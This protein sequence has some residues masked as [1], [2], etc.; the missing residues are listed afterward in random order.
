MLQTVSRAVR[1][2]LALAEQP[3]GLT[4]SELARTVGS[5]KATVHRIVSTLKGFDLIATSG[6]SSRLRIG[7]QCAVLHKWLPEETDIREVARPY[8]TR[9]RDATGET[10]CLHLRFGYERACVDQVES[11]TELKWVAQIG[12]RFP[13]TAG[14]PGKVMVAFLPAEERRRVLQVVPLARFTADSITE[15]GQYERELRNVRRR[16]YSIAVNENVPGS[17]ACAAPIRDRS[18]HVVGALTVAGAADRLSRR[19]LHGIAPLV[20]KAAADLSRDLQRMVKL[21]VRPPLGSLAEQ[22]REGKDGSK[23]GVE[24]PARGARQG[25]SRV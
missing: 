3:D 21:A 14:A 17:A 25:R 9:L 16:G 12:K 22:P 23:R 11:S 6:R 4:L 8:L 7:P 2:L 20:G 24:A 5:N 13:L 1:C 19:R 10:A 18:G 15:P